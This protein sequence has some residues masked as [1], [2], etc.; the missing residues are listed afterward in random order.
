MNIRKPIILHEGDHALTQAEIVLVTN[1]GEKVAEKMW[2]PREKNHVVWPQSWLPLD[3]YPFSLLLLPLHFLSLLHHTTF[4]HTRRGIRDH[5]MLSPGY[6]LDLP[7]PSLLLL[8]L[9]YILRHHIHTV[10]SVWIPFNVYLFC[11]SISPIPISS[12]HN[13]SVFFSIPM[14]HIHTLGTLPASFCDNICCFFKF[15]LWLIVR[16]PY[17]C[18]VTEVRY[19]IET[20]EWMELSCPLLFHSVRIIQQLEVWSILWFSSLFHSSTHFTL[21]SLK[22]RK[23][24][25][26]NQDVQWSSCHTDLVAF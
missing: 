4:T 1:S 3:L 13:T 17:Q 12:H 6:P 22:N 9:S 20:W 5:A 21:Y 16:K 2:R 23:Y 8:F 15:P 14:C 25:L 19:M 18:R 26:K 7:P 24:L 11:P 10:I